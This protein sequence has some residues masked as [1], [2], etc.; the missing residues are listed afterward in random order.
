[1]HYHEEMKYPNVHIATVP[2]PEDCTRNEI[3]NASI[4]QELMGLPLLLSLKSREN[5]TSA[6]IATSALRVSLLLLFSMP[7]FMIADIASVTVT[8][9]AD[10]RNLP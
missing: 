8:G 6:P 1:M 7:G 4:T 3:Q 10:L 9:A 2:S 5:P